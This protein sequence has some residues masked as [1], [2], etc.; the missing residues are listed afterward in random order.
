MSELV[1]AD[2]PI[3]E[4][5]VLCKCCSVSIDICP[6]QFIEFI[7]TYIDEGFVVAEWQERLIQRM[8]IGMDVRRPQSI[9]IITDI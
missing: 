4:G 6:R 7:R 1:R 9:V 5:V 8:L 3:L 2:E